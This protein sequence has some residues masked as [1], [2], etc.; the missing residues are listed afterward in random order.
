MPATSW[1]TCIHACPEGAIISR[2]GTEKWVPQRGTHMPAG[3]LGPAGALKIPAANFGLLAINFG[4]NCDMCLAHTRTRIKK[5][6]T[7]NVHP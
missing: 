2:S 7:Y 6:A 5:I 4:Q 1:H 3:H